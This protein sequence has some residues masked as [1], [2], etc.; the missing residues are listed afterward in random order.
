MTSSSHGGRSQGGRHHAARQVAAKVPEITVMFWI[1]KVLTTGMGEAA[2]DFLANKSVPVAAALGLLGFA[3]G[4]ILQLRTRR[5]VTAVYWFAVAMVALFGTMAADGF[6]KLIGIPYA[7]VTAGYAIAL[8]VIFYLWHRSEGTLSIHS[9]NTPRREIYY[10]LTVLAT[11]ALGTAAGDFTAFT[12]NLG[13]AASSVLYA[14]LILVPLIAYRMR[15][16]NE[17][18]AFWF[19]YVLTRPLGASIADWL[20][21]DKTK[22]GLGYGDGTVTIVAAVLIAVFVA[23]LAWTG[24]DVQA[25]DATMPA[26]PERTAQGRTAPTRTVPGQYGETYRDAPY[27]EPYGN[28]RTVEAEPTDW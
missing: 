10:W 27:G 12:L 11:F 24:A 9:I 1:V 8:A 21:K 5:Y 26:A 19:A 6:H 3:V 20:G 2:S 16:M 13:Y 15:W 18:V 17:V 7:V 28:R 23:Y 4:M 22:N 14:V 25:H